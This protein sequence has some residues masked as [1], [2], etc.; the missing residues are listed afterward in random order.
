MKILVNGQ[1]VATAGWHDRG[2]AYGDG[3]FESMRI[4]QGQILHW[5]LHLARLREGCQRLA[6]SL[7]EA[8][9]SAE[10]SQLCQDVERGVC[11]LILT[12]G[13]GQRGY[14][15]P[16]PAS[17]RRILQLTS[18]PSWP[19][20][21][22]SSG[23]ELYPCKTRLACQPLL[24]GLK[25]LNRLE[26]VLARNEWQSERYAEGLMLDTNDYVIEGVFSNIFF[27]RQQRLLTPALTNSGVA[28]VMRSHIFQLAD[29]LGLACEQVNIKTAELEQMDEIFMCNS[30]YG[31]WPV[32]AFQQWRWPLGTI[33]RKLQQHL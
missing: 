18:L 27:V 7:A 20:Q 24:A 2:L 23:I 30:L 1:S 29:K 4:E 32:R 33:T 31:I 22:F 13:D 25:H 21:N 12:R 5:P 15:M 3:L 10:I 19:E 16:V 9:L 28:G 26:Q 8:E 14:A 6:L 17:C 11:K